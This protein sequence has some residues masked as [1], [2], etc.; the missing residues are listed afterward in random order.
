L[1]ARQRPRHRAHAPA[2]ASEAAARGDRP[3]GK[4]I[5]SGRKVIKVTRRPPSFP[6]PQW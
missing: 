2:M 3:I 1:S 6:L 5:A 4:P